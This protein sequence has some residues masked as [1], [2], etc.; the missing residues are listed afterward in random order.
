MYEYKKH[1]SGK[2][3]KALAIG[4]IIGACIGAYVQTHAQ[5]LLE[6]YYPITPDYICKNGKTYEQ[7]SEGHSVY[8][9]IDKQCIQSQ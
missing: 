2:S 8:I 5:Q 4:L 6:L 3:C 1:N 7:V 9:K